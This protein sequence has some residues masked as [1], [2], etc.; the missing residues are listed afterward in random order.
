MNQYWITTSFCSNL[1][2]SYLSLSLS[3][4]RA[5]TMADLMVGGALLSGFI[6]VL[7]DRLASKE[8]LDFFRGNKLNLKLLKR[9]KTVLLSANALL[10]DAEEKQL[11]DNNVKNWL[12]EL[13][14]VLYEAD[15][16]MDKISTEALRLK[17]EE[18]ELE[19]TA[20]KPFNFV[21][22]NPF[23]ISAVKS[24]IEEILDTLMDL[25]EQ[26]EYL[27]LKK[28]DRKTTLHR[29]HAPLLDDSQVY[30]REG[31]KEAIL[32]LLLCDDDAGPRI[33]FI[34]IVG[35]GGI[36]KT[37]LAQNVFYDTTVQQHFAL[38]VWVTVSD[39]FDV[40][41]ITKIIL[42][43]ITGKEN[44]ANELHQLQKDLKDSLAGKKF[45]FVH[46][47]VWN[48][49]YE[50]WD[51]L[52]SS[53]QS[54]AQGSKI[55]VTTRNGDVALKMK[56]RNVQTYELKNM[57]DD[58]C[59]KLFAEHAFDNVGSNEV[60]LSELQ[61]IG[62]QIVKKCK[63]L[64]LAVKSMASLLRSMSTRDEWRHVLQS[65][66][67]EMPNRQDIEIVP[68]LWLSYRFLPPYL[69]PCF[70][71]LSIFP[72]DYKFGDVDREKLILIWMAEGL[73]KSQPGKRIEDV[74]EEYLNALIARSFFQRNTR[75]RYLSMHDLMH[76]LAMYVSGECCFIYDSCKDLHKFSSKTRHLSYMKVLRDA[77]EFDNLPKAKYLR[78]LLAL[79]LSNI[80][81]LSDA[82][83]T[84]QMVLR[85]GECLRAL[86]LSES[87][88]TKLPSSIENLKYLRYL[89]ISSTNIEELPVSI[90]V[91]YNLETLVLS[92]CGKLTQLPTNISKLINLRHLM[93][94]RTHLKEMPPKIFNMINLWTLSD[95][96][97]CGND[98]S[99][100]KEL[101]K[102]ENLHGSLQILGLGYVK[103][104]SDV[105]EGNL[106]NKKNLTE[107]I[108]R[109]N[110]EADDS[111]KEREVLN[112][113]QPH[114][115]LKKLK[116]HNYNGTNLLDW[117]THPSYSNLEKLH[118]DC[119]NCCLS[120]LSFR[121]LS[122]LRDLNISCLYMHDEFGGISLNMPFALLE[123]LKL[124]GISRLDWSFTNT[125][126]QKCEIFPCLKKFVLSRCGKI[127][128]ALPIGNFPSLKYIDIEECNELVTIFPSSTH[129]DVAY[130]SL[131]WLNIDGCSR[132]ESFSEMG[133][134]SSLKNLR[135]ISCNMLME[136]RMKWNLQR[137]PLLIELYLKNYGGAVDSFPEE[138]LLPP[139]LTLLWIWEFDRLT[140]LNGKGFHHLTSLRRLELHHLEKL[141]CLPAEGLPQTLT[142]LTISGCPVLIP[143][144]KEGTGE[145]WPKIQHI[146]NIDAQHWF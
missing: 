27:G 76:D 92:H 33:S 58:E 3:L 113:L 142:A 13:K 93:I 67:W 53:F 144:C 77:I 26:T 100:I 68:A 43:K 75:N 99:R 71:Y 32:K 16:V 125:D 23:E 116:I 79:P 143:R 82:R 37:T 44:K 131:E 108:L 105:F 66:V 69:K 5:E 22:N 74:G 12:D 110:G 78:S 121:L 45:L 129:I 9:L 98:G 133:L 61:E 112:A 54:G 47:D 64:P 35:M 7:F 124:D 90:C 95:F 15:H 24:E 73:L 145:D 126:G 49:K 50:L 14:E 134:P 130:P 140:A 107:L 6:N 137:L 123:V 91:L 55:I 59:W 86:S 118:L 57:S 60:V 127:N 106:K 39:D 89:D 51:L 138:W 63:G 80:Y 119:K 36:G 25:L 96:V 136:N 114:E 28:V 1:Y 56:T 18:D 65:D 128:V 132:L 146:P 4:S 40:V 122:S 120:L 38:K 20:S 109:W 83:L 19:S 62:R 17:M 84:L 42:E 52:K 34:P 117:V 115:N 102:L 70:S 103:E 111:I 21:S 11:G 10:D 87:N 94:R 85:D 141:E 88:I 2:T 29:T 31:D 101:G 139:S 97:L 46:D 41:K 135:I 48:E 30:G 104:V 81:S 8:V 72:K